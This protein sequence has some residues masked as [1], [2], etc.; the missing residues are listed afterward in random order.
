MLA[1]FR[2]FLRPPCV[3]WR[4][5]ASGGLAFIPS[6]ACGV[7]QNE[8]PLAAMDGSNG[9]S[10]NTNSPDGVAFRLQVIANGI[11]SKGNVAFNIFTNNPTGFEF[12]HDP[13]HVR[14]HVPLVG[15]SAPVPGCTERL[16]GVSTV[17]EINRWQFACIECSHIVKNPHFRPVLA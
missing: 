10:W 8:H 17:Q 15:L 6:I 12:S 7:G 13:Q 2:L 9:A 1:I 3:I 16:A 5:I 4:Y 11:E 14:P